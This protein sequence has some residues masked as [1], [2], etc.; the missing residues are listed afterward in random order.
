MF[1]VRL[2]DLEVFYR[3]G[4]PE[5][6]RAQPQRLMVSVEMDVD[7]AAAAQSDELADTIDYYRVSQDILGF[8]DGRS[9]KLLETLCADLAELVLG[10]HQPRGVRIEVKKFIIPEAR[11]VSVSCAKVPGNVSVRL[12]SGR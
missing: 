2:V 5:A 1:T 3:V 7:A 10:R 9:W 6:E 12:G 4:V 8:G 11:Y